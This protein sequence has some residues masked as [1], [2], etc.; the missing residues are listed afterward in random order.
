MIERVSDVN[1]DYWTIDYGLKFALRNRS[2]SIISRR[3]KLIGISMVTTIR[4]G[5]AVAIQHCAREGA[6]AIKFEKAELRISC[7]TPVALMLRTNYIPFR[8]VHAMVLRP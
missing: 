7:G 8:L 2:P 5:D 4:E 1:L 6:F 3:K